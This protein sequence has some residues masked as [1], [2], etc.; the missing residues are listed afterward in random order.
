MKGCLNKMSSNFD[1][2]KKLLATDKTFK[3]VGDVKP[4][5]SPLAMSTN[6]NYSKKSDKDKSIK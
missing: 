5:K 6:F 2:Q 1:S 4:E 3:T